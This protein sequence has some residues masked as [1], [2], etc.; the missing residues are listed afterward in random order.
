[1]MQRVLD[2]VAGDRP[3]RLLARI[4]R[5][6]AGPWQAVALG[7]TAALA[8]L[9]LRWALSAAYGEASGFMILLPAVIVASLAAGPGSGVVALVACLVGGWLLVVFGDSGVSPFSHIRRVATVNFVI[10]GLF[11]VAVTAAFRRAIRDLDDAL[12]AR[13][14]ADRD[15]DIGRSELRAI[16]EQ[17]SAGVARLDAEGRFV[18]TNARFAAILGR[19]PEA[20]IGTTP[21]DIT[22]P[23][24]IRATARLFERL[25]SGEAGGEVEKRYLTPAGEVV[26]CLASVRRL[27]TAEGEPDG[28]VVVLVD[29]TPLRRADAARAESEARFRLMADTAPSPVWMTDVEARVEF[30][31]RA[32]VEFYGAPM[33]SLLGHVWRAALH[34]DDEA[35]VAAIQA[36]SRPGRLPYGFEARFRRADGAWRWMRCSVNPRFDTDGTFLGYVGMSFDVTE[37]RLALAEARESEE[38]FRAIADTAPVLIWVTDRDRNREFVNEAYVQY[39]GG[40]YETVRTADWR[41]YIHP[42]D[43]ARLVAE[44]LA[45]EATREPFSLE[46]RYRRS[47]GVYRWLKSFSRPRLDAHGEVAGFVGVAF[48]VTDARQAQQDLERLNELLEERVDAALAE[49]ARAEADLMHAQRMEAVGRLTGGVAHDFNNLLTVV[50]GALDI[51]L[52]SDDPARRE[53]LGRAA[54]SAARRGESLT[55]QLLAFSRRQALRPEPTDLN[56]QIASG[57][58]LLRR[59]LAPGVELAL[60]L[61]D[62]APR[63]NVD[64][65]QLEAALLNLVVNASDAVGEGA[66]VCVRTDV[67]TLGDGEDATLAAGDYV[68]LSVADNGAGMSDEI[69]SRAFEP[70]FTTKP[71]GKGT[72]LGLSQVYGFCRQ[73]GGDARI[74]S[75]EGKGA[76]ITLWLPA[77]SGEAAAP[78]VEDPGPAE[79]AD[80][81]GRV[82][83]VEDD[84]AVAAVA[85]ELLAGLGYEVEVAGGAEEALARLAGGERFDLMLTDVIMPG[86]LNGVE[87]GRRVA[88]AYPDVRIV[89]T[90]GYAGEDVAATMAGAPW[91]FL[92]K[93]YSGLELGRALHAA[94]T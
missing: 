30:A 16:V 11:S 51:I 38:R 9:A 87:L 56:A 22:H 44:S 42:D 76:E 14:A 63:A 6:S 61:A 41:A 64:P 62:A 52:R 23:D 78:A 29:L 50:I 55:H 81:A 10:V 75:E 79:A 43:Q 18:E 19:P 34:P 94:L 45:G 70:F 31:N 15:R 73:S 91:P 59:A 35:A 67:R 86:G 26:W 24:D 36:E 84:P 32:L 65:A 82:L 89:L 88:A 49:K 47:D 53:K 92:R 90:S 71:L 5:R 80:G 13:R 8:V 3:G 20:L 58:P 27:A 7:L 2:I 17:S 54:L 39:M 48:D 77:L 85:E 4:A 46:A 21:L 57:E 25:Q 33:E 60:E 40:D 68:L 28:Y 66:R 72:G 12:E 74:H 69:A 93:P 37:Q 83:L 1:M